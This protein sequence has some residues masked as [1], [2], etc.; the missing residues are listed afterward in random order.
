MLFRV[1]QSIYNHLYLIVQ[2]LFH[3]WA[4]YFVQPEFIALLTWLGLWTQLAPV[5]PQIW[6]NQE[7]WR[8]KIRWINNCNEI[9]C[10]QLHRIF[11]YITFLWPHIVIPFPS[12]YRVG[13]VKKYM[14]LTQL[15]NTLDSVST[16]INSF[17]SNVHFA[18]LTA[19]EKTL[20]RHKS[21]WDAVMQN[22]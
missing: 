2:D 3:F 9:S 12:L 4:K 5:E 15:L 18:V 21:N 22:R 1:L 8:L 19:D 20:H 11:D 7:R 13:R 16:D 10:Y 14:R 6:R 17:S